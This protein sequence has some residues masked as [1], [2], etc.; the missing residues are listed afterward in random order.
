LDESAVKRFASPLVVQPSE[1]A[2][3]PGDMVE[4]KKIN[5]GLATANAAWAAIGVEGDGLKLEPTPP[6]GFKVGSFVFL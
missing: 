4:T 2:A 1:D 3:V 6:R 5:L